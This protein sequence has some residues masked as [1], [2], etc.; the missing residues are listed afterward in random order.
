MAHL[1][2][3]VPPPDT[4]VLVDEYVQTVDLDAP[5][6]LVGITCSSPNASHVYGL[7]DAFRAR[8]RMVVLGGPHPTLLP[9]EARPHADALVIGEAETTWPQLLADA[10]HGA[11]ARSV[12]LTSRPR[13]SACH[14]RAAT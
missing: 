1:A 11:L 2:G 12:A 8:G 14:D 3:F 4:V 6:D 9:D 7:A 5:A 13:W 10:V